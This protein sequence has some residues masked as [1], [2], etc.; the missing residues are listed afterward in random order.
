MHYTVVW[1]EDALDDLAQIWMQSANRNSVNAASNQVDKEL[2]YSP[3]TKG[4][5]FCGIGYSS[6]RPFMWF[7]ECV[8]T[9]C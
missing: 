5:Y 1:E 8:R 7:F 6:F 4:T 3:E 9:I 2:A